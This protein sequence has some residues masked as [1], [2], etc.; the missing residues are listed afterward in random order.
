MVYETFLHTIHSMVQ[1]RLDGKANVTLQQVLKNNGVLLDGLTISEPDSQL[2]PTIYLNAY[3]E[4]AEKGLPL[5]IISEQILL[6]YETNSD[7]KEEEALQMSEFQHARNQ[8]AYKLIHAE[9][10]EELLKDLPHIPYLDL[11]VIFYYIVTENENGQMTA[12]IRNEHLKLWGICEELLIQTAME[13]TPRL[14]P[15]QI[16]SLEQTLSHLEKVPLYPQEK[17]PSVHLQVLTNCRGINGAACLLYPG[18]L[19]KFADQ[20]QD[21]LI[22]IPSSI[23]EILLTG[24]RQAL[25]IHEL[26]AMIHYI[27]QTEVPPEDRLSDH[28]YCYS[29]SQQCL[30]IPSG[31]ASSSSC[32]SFERTEYLQ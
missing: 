18:V 32:S 17:S 19:K 3:Y 14:L 15:V 20:E 13:N 29:R 25:P 4:E 22:L 28:I 10:N 26:N 24:Q 23:H 31:S 1:K 5:S 27:N 8:I 30:Y 21:D 9:T 16:T 2:A 6:L 12:L 7:L 11:A